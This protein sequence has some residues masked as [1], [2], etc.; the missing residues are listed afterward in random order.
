MPEPRPGSTVFVTRRGEER[1][2]DSVARL[3][4]IAQIVGSLVAIVAI[5]RQ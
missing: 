4:V 2:G 1:G 5:T 3:A